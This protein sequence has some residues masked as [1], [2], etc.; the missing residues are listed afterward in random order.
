MKKFLAIY[1][2][3]ELVWHMNFLTESE[4]DA[5]LKLQKNHESWK[6]EF[7]VEFSDIDEPKS[8][9][10]I[11]AQIDAIKLEREQKLSPIKVKL[12]ALGL[13]SEEVQTL[14]GE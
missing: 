8:E 13:S 9:E 1:N 2:N 14:I 3:N 10:E 11:H 5:W 7:I 6:E 12:M 4:R